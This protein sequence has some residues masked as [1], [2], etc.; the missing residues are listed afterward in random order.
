MSV[1]ALEHLAE[2]LVLTEPVGG[3]HCPLRASIAYPAEKEGG[4]VL[5]IWTKVWRRQFDAREKGHH[6]QAG[7]R[8]A[9]GHASGRAARGQA[10]NQDRAARVS[11]VIMSAQLDATKAVE[12][13]GH[14]TFWK[15]AM[16]SRAN[17]VLLSASINVYGGKKFCRTGMACLETVNGT[18]SILAGRG[19]AISETVRE[20]ALLHQVLRH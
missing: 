10:A 8:D 7:F 17:L 9:K 15:E 4:G 18:C 2:L 6:H 14:A 11:T 5:R 16:A 13:N 3:Q 12:W 1:E 19:Y 20:A